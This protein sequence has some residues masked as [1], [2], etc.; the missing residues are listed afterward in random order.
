MYNYTGLV[1][2]QEYTEEEENLGRHSVIGKANDRQEAEGG[3][4]EVRK[5]NETGGAKLNRQR[6]AEVRREVDMETNADKTQ[7]GS[8]HT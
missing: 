7:Q 2:R 8:R 1:R 6:T 3:S 4:G 5:A